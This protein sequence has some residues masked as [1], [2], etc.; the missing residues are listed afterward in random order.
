MG[1]GR[2]GRKENQE[3]KQ[4]KENNKTVRKNCCPSLTLVK[5]GRVVIDVTERDVNSGGTSEPPQLAAHVLG[6]DDH[7][8][9]FSGLPVHVC[10]GHTDYA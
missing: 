1:S 6:L 8:V 3:R 5:H 10:Q 7:S 2:A 9:V 4:K